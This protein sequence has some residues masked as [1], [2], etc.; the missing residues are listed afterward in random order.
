MP[1]EANVSDVRAEHQ[2]PQLPNQTILKEKRG[3]EGIISTHT[4]TRTC[5][6]AHMHKECVYVCFNVDA[7]E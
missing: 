7:L 1:T 2:R 3:W 4:N 6:S 5:V